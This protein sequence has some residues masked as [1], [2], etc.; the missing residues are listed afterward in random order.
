M[1]TI[2]KLQYNYFAVNPFKMHARNGNL[3]CF[4]KHMK[5]LA[6]PAMRRERGK[7]VNSKV[8]DLFIKRRQAA[9]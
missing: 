7:A 8:T 1:I 5:N 2:F 6:I 9:A 4:C 3:S